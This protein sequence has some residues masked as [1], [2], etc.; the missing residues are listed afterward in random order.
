MSEGRQCLCTDIILAVYK[1]SDRVNLSAWSKATGP[2]IQISADLQ[3][4]SGENATL[5]NKFW[6]TYIY[7]FK[8]QEYFSL[9]P[10]DLVT[11]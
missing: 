6:G 4:T 9:I 3:L 1:F 10:K 2:S 11:I 8:Y 7:I 5:L